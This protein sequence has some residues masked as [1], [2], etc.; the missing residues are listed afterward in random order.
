MRVLECPKCGGTDLYYEAGMVTGHKYHC[1]RCG[2][3]GVFV[4]ERD[5]EASPEREDERPPE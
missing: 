2:Y 4:I 5:V 3:I 1:K